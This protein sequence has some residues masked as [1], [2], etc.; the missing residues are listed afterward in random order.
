[1]FI[2]P[3]QPRITFVCAHDGDKKYSEQPKWWYADA[4]PEMYEAAR[5]KYE[6]ITGIKPGRH[7]IGTASVGT[8]K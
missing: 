2:S 7:D 6:R 1:M 8:G 4:P 3:F 5:D